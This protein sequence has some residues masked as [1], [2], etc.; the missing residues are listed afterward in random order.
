MGDTKIVATI[1]PASMDD[2]ILK[3]LAKNGVSVLRVNTAHSNIDDIEKLKNK[4]EK[5]NKEFK[6]HIGIMLDLKGPELRTIDTENFLIK[7][8]TEYYLADKKLNNS[9]IMINRPEVIKS[10]KKN[11]HILM[12][13]GKITFRVIETND[14]YLKMVALNDGILR[15]HSRINIPGRYV[16]V[17]ILTEQ[18]KA[19]L[20]NGIK[21]K[22]DF[23]ALSFVQT[24]DNVKNLRKAIMENDGDQSIIS[25]IETKTGLENISEIIKV[26]D[27]IMVAR[28]DLGV[29]L[30]LE[31]IGIT[32]KNIIRESHKFGIPTIVATQML[33]SMVKESSPTR[34][35]VSDI[36]N[37]ILDN[38][39]AVMLSEETAIGKYPDL[40]VLNM[41]KIIDYVESKI[42]D[43]PEPEEF[44]GNRIAFSIARASKMIAKEIEADGILGFTN[45]GNTAK[46]LS[47]V[48]P[49]IPI[50]IAVKNENL[51]RKLNLLRG[52]NTFIID[53][54]NVSDINETLNEMKRSFN[55]RKGA[56]L[57]VA[58]GAPYFFLGGTNSVTAITIG[59]FLGRGYPVG[60]SFSGK[61]TLSG[62]KGNILVVNKKILDANKEFLNYN[63]I[64]FTDEVSPEVMDFLEKNKI[65]ALYNT[66]LYKT[67]DEGDNVFIDGYTGTMIR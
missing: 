41:K 44:L 24:K 66:K 53:E 7:S 12:S 59:E 39:D 3:N 19:F 37:A 5:L 8:N 2:T 51:A 45:H 63:G 43:F 46:M 48:R 35:E 54:K 38:A 33:E 1:G 17:G 57:V 61:I 32:Q 6:T 56:R 58:S 23:F 60:K 64:I 14:N 55:I 16:D 25:K 13:D 42:K 52:I 49:G 4:V 10:I 26:S 30:P 47:A 40:A 20:L 34:A 21:N 22:V 28:G 67:P 62:W 27:A 9:Y 65:S 11:D 36:T 18:D 29:E 15:D 50:Y 31:E